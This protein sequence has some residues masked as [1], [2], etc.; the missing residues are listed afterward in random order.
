[1]NLKYKSQNQQKEEALYVQDEVLKMCEVKTE[2][3]DFLT[4]EKKTN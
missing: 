4:R 1:M 3:D 2:D